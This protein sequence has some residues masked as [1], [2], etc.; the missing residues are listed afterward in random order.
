MRGGDRGD[1]AE[2]ADDGAVF[3]APVAAGRL[4]A[5]RERDA[6]TARASRS[7]RIGENLL[8]RLARDRLA[9]VTPSA[10]APA[11]A[12]PAVAGPAAR[13]R[14]TSHSR[15]R[16]GSAATTSIGRSVRADD[17]ARREV[18]G[19]AED[20]G[21]ERRGD[22][23]ARAPARAR[24]RRVPL[25]TS[26]L[27]PVASPG[28]PAATVS[29]GRPARAITRGHALEQHRGAGLAP[30]RGRRAPT[31]RAR[32]PARASGKSVRN[33]PG[34]RREHQRA[35]PA[36]AAKLGDRALKG[37]QRIGVEH[38]RVGPRATSAA[39]SARRPASR[40]SPGPITTA[41][42]RRDQLEQRRRSGG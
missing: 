29:G 6:R 39:T 40:P 28:L 32:A 41:S 38:D 24:C 16:S 21:A 36:S 35:A 2:I 10:A 15:Q 3:G 31:D 7:E 30:R 12:A 13:R 25:S 18:G 34:M 17:A 26:P 27:P 37:D 8:R 20:L 14:S 1:A 33:S 42:A 5:A 22:R 11:R 4:G 9:C 23:R 19:A